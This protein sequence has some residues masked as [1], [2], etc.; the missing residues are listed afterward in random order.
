[1]KSAL[2]ITQW[3]LTRGG[4]PKSIKYDILLKKHSGRREL[5]PPSLQIAEVLNFTPFLTTSL[6]YAHPREALLFFKGQFKVYD[7]INKIDDD[8]G[9]LDF[10]VCI[11]PKICP[12][13]TWSHHSIIQNKSSSS[14]HCIVSLIN[15]K[16][17]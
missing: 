3:C 15:D 17:I 11:Q 7:I 9:H 13:T 10:Q 5:P 16:K 2:D 4:S 12:K 6:K 8:T 14:L 1:M